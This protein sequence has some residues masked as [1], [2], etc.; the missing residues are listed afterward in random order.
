VSHT[1]PS[2]SPA[3]AKRK[4]CKK[5]ALDLFVFHTSPLGIHCCG[6]RAVFIAF[7]AA[8]AAVAV[9]AV[10]AVVA[11]PPSRKPLALFPM[12]SLDEAEAV[13][14]ASSREKWHNRI[15]SSIAFFSVGNLHLGPVGLAVSMNPLRSPGPRKFVPCMAVVD[16]DGNLGSQLPTFE[17]WPVH[18]SEELRL[19]GR[20]LQDNG[21]TTDL[22]KINHV[23]ENI[24]EFTGGLAFGYEA[25]P[26]VCL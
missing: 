19:L 12:S 26:N 3:R 13:V 10:V 20:S 21:A 8:A 4:I 23:V 2:G 5:E 25:L 9:V 24:A 18:S 6:W 7:V 11:A 22:S 15:S 1:S 17:I 14:F 16:A